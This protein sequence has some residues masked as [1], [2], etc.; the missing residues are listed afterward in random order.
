MAD[1][2]FG[3]EQRLAAVK[4]QLQARFRERRYSSNFD[5]LSKAADLSRKK[6]N[7]LKKLNSTSSQISIG[8]DPAD[9]FSNTGSA[10]AATLATTTVHGKVPKSIPCFYTKS[11]P[12][13]LVR[14]VATGTRVTLLCTTDGRCYQFGS[15][16]GIQSPPKQVA[17]LEG[18]IVVQVAVGC[19][20]AKPP[21]DAVDT[22]VKNK[23]DST[24]GGGA[25]ADND[26]S[27]DNE[28]HMAVLTAE[29]ESNLYTWGG[30][31]HG[32]LGR[33]SKGTFGWRAEAV[34]F[35]SDF[36]ERISYVVTGLKFTIA[37]TEM[38]QVYSW[39]VNTRGQCGLGTF[40][41]KASVAAGAAGAS[42]ATSEF[43]NVTGD[44]DIV[45]PML[46]TQLSGSNKKKSRDDEYDTHGPF[47]TAV[48]R[49]ENEVG[50]TE[51]KYQ[52]RQ[53]LVATGVS[54]ALLWNSV[55]EL[56]PETSHILS[57][58]EKDL[59]DLETASAMLQDRLVELSLLKSPDEEEE[60]ED[61]DE[62][63]REE[64][65]DGSDDDELDESEHRQKKKKNEEEEENKLQA[66]NT[67]ELK[68]QR[69]RQ[70]LDRVVDSKVRDKKIL[71]TLVGGASEEG[72]PADAATLAAVSRD[73]LVHASVVAL[74]SLE[75]RIRQSRSKIEMIKDAKHRAAK[76]VESVETRVT[77]SKTNVSVLQDFVEDVPRLAKHG[78][79]GASGRES[80]NGGS[81]SSGEGSKESELGRNT[82]SSEEEAALM[83]GL[84][85][86]VAEDSSQLILSDRTILNHTE[87]DQDR[88]YHSVVL[89]NR[90]LVTERGIVSRLEE[91]YKSLL[92]VATSR[93][94]IVMRQGKNVGVDAFDAAQMLEEVSHALSKCQPFS[95]MENKW[96]YSVD[97]QP[98]Y[99]KAAGQSQRIS[100]RLLND[101]SARINSSHY[102]HE[103]SGKQTE[104]PSLQQLKETL[105]N[106]TSD[107][108]LSQ[109]SHAHA[110]E[111]AGVQKGG[112]SAA[113]ELMKFGIM[114]LSET[115]SIEEETEKI[116]SSLLPNSKKLNNV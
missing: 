14:A 39:G 103:H 16:G 7:R 18:K 47:G 11:L 62:E 1:Q 37:V 105:A 6:S 99:E 25:S 83:K 63:E 108:H 23:N 5:E 49:E 46:M 42:G 28:D 34:S 35:G 109:R 8:G 67:D 75:E 110:V 21:S 80:E 66:H 10:S 78:T 32:Q 52:R 59:C 94:K 88:L 85:H 87:K 90:D 79:S 56:S 102:V 13:R 20:V 98:S 101:L 27:F 106:T 24:E 104:D 74:A 40:K 61:E 9:V 69:R 73:K 92:Q 29:R 71:M 53:R 81:D 100:S 50:T 2:A 113:H 111:R 44:R 36:H 70:R 84:I 93:A 77:D 72:T 76:E 3:D 15:F 51:V 4:M 33:G 38:N 68:A 57:E 91:E 82:T 41:M 45:F 65:D 17:Q 58:R 116:V 89:H 64:G 95:L 115:L 114:M 19:G 12:S 22:V 60:D 48:F 26:P 97:R 55:S 54:H 86:A 112:T 31:D 30:N 96:K 43:A 107:G